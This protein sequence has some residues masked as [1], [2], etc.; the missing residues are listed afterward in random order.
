MASLGHIPGFAETISISF[1]IL[2]VEVG[3]ELIETFADAWV[4]SNG[5]HG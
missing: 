4:T 2:V 3:F 5:F 1:S